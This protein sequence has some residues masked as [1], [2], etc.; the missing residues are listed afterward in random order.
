MQHVTHLIDFFIPTHY[1]LAL[2]IDRQQRHFTGQ[3]TIT[4][5]TTQADTPIKLH[6]KDLTITSATID[7]QPA[8]VEHNEDEISLHLPTL[9]AGTHTIT[10]AYEAAITDSLHGLYPCYYQHDGVKK[11]LL[12]TQFE[13]HHARE[14]FPCIDEPAA[15][16]TFDITVT[17]EP[18]ITVL[19]NMPVQSQQE[20]DGRLITTFTQTPRMSTYLVALVMGELQH[21]TG[22]TKDGVEVSVWA[23]PAQ[24]PASLDFA[25]EHAI[26]SIE[27]FNEYFDTPYPLPKSDHVA[28]PDFSS[29]AM[30]NWGLITYRESALL[31]DPTTTTIADKQYIATVISHELSHQ[32]FGNLVTMK[33]WDN[34]WLN[35]SFANMMEYLAVDAI[36]RFLQPRRCAGL[37]P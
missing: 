15:K 19:G 18:G 21:I 4:G 20:A 11:E 28:V 7:G 14:V 25:L 29:G 27:F 12:M 10:L 26:R 36:H 24:A 23:T 34:L 17:T 6:A 2:D 5:E 22:Q 30:E 1:Q 3:V 37:W 16:A 32:W 13:S 9:S 33:W 8:S 35:E 31:A